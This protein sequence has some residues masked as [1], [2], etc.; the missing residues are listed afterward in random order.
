MLFGTPS[1]RK[2]EELAVPH[3][4]RWHRLSSLISHLLPLASCLLPCIA[5]LSLTS[6]CTP[7]AAIPPASSPRIASLAPNLTEIAYAVG[8]GDALIGRTDVCDY[9]PECKAL[10][11]IGNFGRA[12]PEALAAT[13]ANVVMCIEFE[14][15]AMLE[16]IKQLGI[17]HELI[18]CK[19]L[20]DIPTAIMR[21]GALAGCD[22]KAAELSA[23]IADGIAE[24]RGKAE[25]VD[26]D[27][28]PVVF[29][30]MWDSPLITAGRDSFM[31]EVVAL[32]GGRNLGDELTER[33][34]ASVSEELVLA[35]NPDVIICLYGCDNE[36]ARKRIASRVGWSGVKAVKE[37]RIY[38]EFDLDVVC[39]PGPRV[40]QGI[41]S[42][43]ALIGRPE[44]PD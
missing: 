43:A 26:T 5:L 19:R 38:A 28:K 25:S 20:A 40:V 37:N 22:E 9:P 39:R 3:P 2:T 35:R 36:S 1:S 12:F 31:S 29:L 32:A 41:E 42:I 30:E 8:A 21:V 4:A 27:D 18:P 7:N 11:V 10:P 15:M 16:A 34:Y 13:R 17:R 24:W 6:G 23:S 44:N 33:D 14:D